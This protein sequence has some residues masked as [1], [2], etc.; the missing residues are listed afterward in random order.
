MEVDSVHATIER[1]TKNQDI[2]LPT[3]YINV[4]IPARKRNPYKVKY[5]DHNF[6]NDYKSVC[7]ITSIKPSKTVGH[8]YVTDFRQLKYNPD[9]YIQFNLSYCEDKCEKLPY[10]INL[11]R[12]TPRRDILV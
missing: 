2:K 1:A 7:D 8:P 10:E 4:I 5:L 3:D 9:G 6:F 11:Y 12:R